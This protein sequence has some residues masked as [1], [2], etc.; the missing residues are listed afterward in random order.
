MVTTVLYICGVCNID[1]VN[2]IMAKS[3]ILTSYCTSGNYSSN[4][5]YFSALLF[6]ANIKLRYTNINR[7]HSME[8][9]EKIR[10]KIYCFVAEIY[11][12]K[13][14]KD[15]SSYIL[16]CQCK[17]AYISASRNGRNMI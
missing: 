14:Y 7:G 1:I 8:H 17:N 15:V 12:F 6:C 13:V 5:S 10:M 4:Y 2:F 11:G 3:K 16:T 9:A